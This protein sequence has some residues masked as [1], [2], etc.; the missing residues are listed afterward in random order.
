MNELEGNLSILD[1]ILV[2][3]NFLALN[4]CIISAEVEFICELFW[5]ASEIQ[6]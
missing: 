4:I 5:Q 1:Q 3:I 2:E 6:F